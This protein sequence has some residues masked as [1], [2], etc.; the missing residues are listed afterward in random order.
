MHNITNSL[1]RIEKEC[2]SQFSRMNLLLKSILKAL[3][4]GGGQG[5]QGKELEEE[6]FIE[7]EEKEESQGD[8]PVLDTI[9]LSIIRS[10][11]STDQFCRN[12]H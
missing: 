11:L 8:H 7:Q 6:Q 1:K 4:Q 12:L 9:R 5:R 10:R 3:E 2:E